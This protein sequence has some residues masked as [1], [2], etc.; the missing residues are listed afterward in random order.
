[1]MNRNRR[2]ALHKR[3][4]RHITITTI[5][6][7]ATEHDE[8]Q[9]L[10]IVPQPRSGNRVPRPLHQIIKRNAGLPG[11]R[12]DAGHRRRVEK[13]KLRE[14]YHAAIIPSKRRKGNRYKNKQ[15]SKTK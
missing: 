6:A 9:R 14:E 5:I 15:N 7:A 10:W 3:P 11:R 1:M 12:I 2:T 8:T 13:G 4:R